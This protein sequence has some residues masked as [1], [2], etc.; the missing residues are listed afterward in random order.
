MS[1]RGGGGGGGGGGGIASVWIVQSWRTEF[2]SGSDHQYSSY[3]HFDTKKFTIH[4]VFASLRDANECAR[5]IYREMKDDYPES[6]EE[7][8][9]EEVIV[10]DDD[11]DLEPYEYED[12]ECPEDWETGILHIRVERFEIR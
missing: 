4:G 1:S 5:G 2:D 7:E 8:E 11:D 12:D 9:E 3:E 6:E 10:L